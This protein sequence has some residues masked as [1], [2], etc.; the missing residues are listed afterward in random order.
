M[1]ST[2]RSA[3]LS[4]E[5]KRALLAQFLRQEASASKSFPAS[6]AQQRLWFLDQL[7]PGNPFYNLFTAIRL[8]GRLNVIALVQSFNVIVRRHE[9]LRTTFAS[10]EGDLQ[11]VIAPV[12]TMILSVVDLQSVPKPGR[13]AVV[14]RLAVIEAQRPFDLAR[15]PLLRVTVLRLGAAAHVVLLSTHHIAVDGWSIG[16]FMQELGTLYTAYATEQPASLPALSIQ[17][18]D[19]AVWQRQRLQGAVLEAQLAYWKQQLA[20]L[21]V[22]QLPTDRPRPAA[23]TFQGARQSLVLSE[24]LSEALRALSRR[25]RVTLFMVLLAAF[26]VLLHRYTGQDDIVVGA[27]IAGRNHPE[28]EALIGFF[29]NMLVLRIN[30]AGNPI[31]R[32]LLRQVRAVALGA[33]AHQELP[34]EK[35]VEEL[36]PERDLRGHPLLDVVLNFAAAPRIALELPDLTLC[37]IE[38]SESTERFSLT[39]HVLEQ[40]GVLH[41]SVSYQR[42]LFSAARMTCFLQQLRYLLEQIVAAPVTPIHAYTLVTP[43]SQSV[44]PDPRAVLPEPHYESVMTMFMA[45]AAHT[46]TQ[47]AVCQGAQ[48]RTYDALAARAQ[49]LARLLLAQGLERGAVVAVCGPRSFGLIAS[50]LAVL[51]SGGVLLLIDPHLPTR[52]QQL[53]LQEADSKHLIDVGG[54]QLTAAWMSALWPRSLL[55]VE[56]ATGWPVEPAW[57]PAYAALALP[58]LTGDDA[59]YLFFTSGTTGVPKGVLGCHKGLSHFLIWQRQTFAVGPADRCAQL[60]NLSFDVVLRDVFLPLISGATLCLP[61][62][63]AHGVFAPD[64]VLPWLDHA[65]ISLLHTVPT[66]AQAW[67]ANL[68]AGVSLCTLRWVFFAG[69][70]LPEALVRRWRVAF[71]EGGNLVNLYGPTE[72]TLAK[73]FYQVPD[74][75]PP[76]VQPIGWTLP[77]TQALVLA[78][79]GQLCGIGEV[80]EIVLRTPFR[81]RGYINAPEAQRQQFVPN[82]FRED[83][84]DVLYHTGDRGRYQPDGTLEILGRLDH[85]VKIRGVRVEPEEVTALLLQHPAVQAC[86]VVAQEPEPNQHALV[87]YV[88]ASTQGRTTT[89]DLRVYLSQQ[90]PAVMVPSAFVWLDQLPL[91]AHGKVDRRAL[92]APDWTQPEQIAAYVA[93]RTPV[94]EVL[95]GLWAEVLGVAAVGIHDDFFALGGHSLLAAQVMSRV[96]RTFQI[97]LPLRRL[98]ETPTVGGLAREIEVTLQAVQGIQAPPLQPVAREGPLPLSFAQQR[99]WFFNQLEPENPFYNVHGAVCLKGPLH[100][101]AL[102]QTFNAI[103][104]RHEILRTTFPAMQ[105]RPAQVIAPRLT[106]PLQVVDLQAGREIEAEAVARCL[107]MQEARRPFDLA[108]GP[109][110]RVT[111]LRLAQEAHMAIFTMHHIVSDGW[112]RSVLL[113]EVTALYQ[114]FSTGSAPPLPELPIQYADFAHWQRQWLQGEVLE[115]QLAYWQ[116]KLA[117]APT[118]LALPTDRPP[119]VVPTWRGARHMVTLPAALVASLSTLSY[120]QGTTL[121]MTMLTALNIVLHKLSGQTDIVVGT[122]SGNRNRPECEALIG[123]FM[124]FLPLRSRVSDNETGL[125]LLEQVKTTVLEMY[126][127]QDCP[128]E[129]LVEAVNPDRQHHQNPFCNVALF[130]QNYPQFPLSSETL[131]VCFIPLET[132]SIALDLLF[133]VREA[134]QATSLECH[135]SIDLFEADTMDHLVRSYRD[136]LQQLTQHPETQ[137]GHFALSEVLETRA[138]AARDRTYTI[139]IASTFTAEPLEN[140][141]GFWMQELG[142]PFRVQ[143]A[144]YNQV[145]QQLFDTTSP[146][147]TNAYGLNVILVR[148]E[149]WNSYGVEASVSSSF[150]TENT[151]TQQVRAIVHAIQTAVQGTTTPYLVCVCPA[152]STVQADADRAVCFEQMEALLASELATTHGVYVVTTSELLTTYP[153]A[154]PDDPHAGQRAHTPYTDAFYAALGAMIGRKIYAMTHAPHKVIVLDCDGTLWRRT[155][156]EDGVG[157]IALDLPYRALQEFMLAQHDAGMLLCVCSKNDEEDVLEVFERCPDMLLRR[158]HIVSWQVNWR[159]KSENIKRLAEELQLGLESF[160]FLDDNP[161]ECVEVQTNCPDVLTLQLPQDPDSIPGFL[162]HVWAFDYVQ[163]TAKD[164]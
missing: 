115:A 79:N 138:Q 103:V 154:T 162:R 157:G 111:L 99:L 18:A 43:E 25:E 59:A 32:T 58:T 8:T 84:R 4:T 145:F 156:G 62:A 48:A 86:I 151:I 1:S 100:V 70:P 29:V 28:T 130:L 94:E 5:Q 71:P 142:M 116:E 118:A 141:L 40:Q 22:L 20:D 137:I 63:D 46:P 15:G 148:F 134:P 35:L 112:S 101:A 65:R 50:M 55:S 24:P 90:L 52:R 36:H 74:E 77:Q 144:S 120:R 150:C 164:R 149:D 97:E 3:N 26:S 72:T 37:P 143:F 23:Q 54:E 117:A 21:P 88:V 102:A 126:T 6:F 123:C 51:M 106:V 85:Q 93:P 47:I 147:S 75:P 109:L 158:E 42:A 160:I 128:F 140:A 57:D 153:V 49:T 80:G 122:M 76:G 69:E 7:A 135:Y 129:K 61:D 9:V 113:R 14:Q 56:P 13:A 127:H 41:L 82:H 27:P 107:A 19:F 125:Q 44:L 95:V 38:L 96:R 104:Q 12:L 78:D 121:F 139:A 30:L 53:M 60:T 34:F 146:L 136:T 16:I 39:L 108:R 91:T 83:A 66:L 119:P 2:G 89:S 67:L 131:D 31:F 81:T 110:L 161:A 124:N 133:I 114:A 17:Y 11:Q 163:I 105:G 64:H 159:S 68:S 10:V 132:Q 73:C 33:S 92:P 98:F 87:A 45:W 155:C 152:S